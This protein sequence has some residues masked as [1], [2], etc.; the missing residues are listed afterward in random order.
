M[1]FFP[2]AKI[3]F[4]LRITGKRADGYHDLETVFYPAGLC[5]A[6]EFVEAHKK[7]VK[8]SITITGINPGG[9]PGDNLVI[10][11]VHKLRAFAGFPVLRIHLHKAIPAAAGLGGG[12][13]DAVCMLKALNRHYNLNI[14]DDVIKSLALELGSDCPFFIDCQPSYATGRGEKM[15]PVS[16]FL[17]GLYVVIANPGVAIS[18]AEAFKNCIPA[19]AESK[20]SEQLNLPPEKWK[21]QVKND[22]EAF[23]FKKYPV[24]GHIKE[25]MYRQGAVFSLMSGSGSSVY[26][27]FREKRVL[28]SNLNRYVVWEGKI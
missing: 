1:I 4:G 23:A 18:T 8:D 26:G 22:F 16:K 12:S 24:I 25:E 6:L 15:V 20:L 13:S 7:E 27:L 10:K 17:S 28:D 5:D 19:P 3:N 11:S 21:D 2:N 9:D 14:T